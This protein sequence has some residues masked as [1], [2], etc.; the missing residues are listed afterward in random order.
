MYRLNDFQRKVLITPEEVVFHATTQDTVNMR[1]IKQA[2]II[3]E[4]RLVR[5]GLGDDFYYTL[6]DEKNLLIDSINKAAQQAL[7]DA[8]FIPKGTTA[9]ELAEGDMVNAAEYLST[10][11]A[12]LWKQHLWKLT[13]ECTML[14]AASDSFVQ[15][16]S[17]GVVHAQPQSG[18][19][20]GNVAVSPDLRTVKWSM[21][22]KMMDRI[23]PLVEA[24][25]QWLCRQKDADQSAYPNYTK[26]CLCNSKGVSYKRKTDFI[27]GIYPTEREYFRDPNVHPGCCTEDDSTW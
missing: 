9:K 24:M 16:S 7:I 21:D 18:P 2:I 27:L 3:A 11:N 10:E 26:T 4:E 19:M 1:F 13:A 25:H 17:S 23:D 5:P 8:S 15:F 22:K 14:V 12:A 20:T 6:L